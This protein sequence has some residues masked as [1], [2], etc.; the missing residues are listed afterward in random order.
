M[1]TPHNEKQRL[2]RYGAVGI[3]TNLA[4]YFVFVLF[5][6]LGL[7]ATV[8][9]ALCYGLGVIMSYMLNRYWTFSST[10]THSRDIPKFLLAYG[11]GLVSTL[12]TITLLMLW[13]PPELAQ[14]INIGLTALV[15]YS[16]LRLIRFGQ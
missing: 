14:I 13:L 2:Y 6:R 10:V 5:L 9:A 3:A 11:V 4:L 15:I 16:S 1:N 7:A 8:A 12:L